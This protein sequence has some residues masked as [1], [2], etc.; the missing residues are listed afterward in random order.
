MDGW[1]SY[2]LEECGVQPDSTHHLLV[3]TIAPQLSNSKLSVQQLAIMLDMSRRQLYRDVHKLLQKPVG[4][5]IRELRLYKAQWL[6]IE[7]KTSDISELADK[8]GFKSTHHFRKIYR[9]FFGPDP[10]GHFP[11]SATYLAYKLDERQVT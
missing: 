3:Q 11:H 6:I 9:Q 2:Y 7:N 8:V 10:A 4:Q 1:I 5:W